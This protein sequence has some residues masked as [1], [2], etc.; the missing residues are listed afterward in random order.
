MSSISLSERGKP[1]T[2]SQILHFV[3][4]SLLESVNAFELLTFHNTNDVTNN[5]TELDLVDSVYAVIEHKI[6]KRPLPAV[7]SIKAPTVRQRLHQ[8]VVE[9]IMINFDEVILRCNLVFAAH[10]DDAWAM[11]VFHD[12]P[13]GENSIEEAEDEDINQLVPKPLGSVDVLL[14]TS[15]ESFDE[16][17]GGVRARSNATCNNETS[18]SAPSPTF[19]PSISQSESSPSLLADSNG[20]TEQDSSFESINDMTLT[21]SVTFETVGSSETRFSLTNG[22]FHEDTICDSTDSFTSVDAVTFHS[23]SVALAPVTASVDPS[24]HDIHVNVTTKQS[25]SRRSLKHHVSVR[26]SGFKAR[27]GRSKTVHVP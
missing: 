21:R 8:L 23:V 16:W 14:R 26:W 3:C 7:M 15:N 13:A 25:S 6:L 5:T 1:L 12:D 4:Q 18:N 24:R 2:N 27:F 20:M 17:H 11:P 19:Q 9:R 10:R 22:F